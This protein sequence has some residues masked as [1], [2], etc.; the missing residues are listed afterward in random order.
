MTSVSFSSVYFYK[1]YGYIPEF[2]LKN[3]WF[4]IKN[5]DKYELAMHTS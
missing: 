4:L 5:F 3:K 2:Q 1:Q